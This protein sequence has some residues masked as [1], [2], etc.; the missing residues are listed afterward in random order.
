MSKSTET[1]KLLKE[2]IAKISDK[3]EW[4][5][6]LG[7]V[8]ALDW[9]EGEP[10]RLS[11]ATEQRIIT[12]ACRWTGRSTK[13]NNLV[14]F[15]PGNPFLTRKL[16]QRNGAYAPNIDVFV[17]GTRAASAIWEKLAYFG[18][19][20][21]DCFLPTGIRLRRLTN[22]QMLP[23]ARYAYVEWIQPD[24]YIFV[25]NPQEAGSEYY[26]DDPD[27]FIIPQRLPC[28]KIRFR[29]G[30]FD[31]LDRDASRFFEEGSIPFNDDAPHAT[32]FWDFEIQI[33]DLAIA[34]LESINNIIP[35]S[36]QEGYK[37][38]WR[39]WLVS[40]WIKCI[41]DRSHLESISPWSGDPPL[42]N[43]NKIE[44]DLFLRDRWFYWT[45]R[46]GYWTGAE[47]AREGNKLWKIGNREVGYLETLHKEDAKKCRMSSNDAY[48]TAKKWVA[49]YAE[50]VNAEP[51]ADLRSAKS[52]S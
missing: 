33:F 46:C 40:D 4:C 15:T 17:I 21:R 14:S 26:D 37:A 45:L 52:D 42:T 9:Q 2:A 36:S 16:Y 25:R 38:E 5:I 49:K 48:K 22:C 27:Q 3:P 7:L 39:E 50:L 47:A 34:S 11:T 32:I 41:A 20:Q 19:D 30:D 1:H 10:R 43:M 24:P 31:S 18:Y 44:K 13:S 51:L 28:R 29:G 35:K 6:V 12:G 23:L 8:N